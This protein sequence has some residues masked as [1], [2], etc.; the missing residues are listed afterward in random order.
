MTAQLLRPTRDAVAQACAAMFSI[1]ARRIARPRQ[2]ERLV[3]KKLTISHSRNSLEL[4]NSQ[5]GD[6]Y[7]HDPQNILKTPHETP[8]NI[9]VLGGGLTGLSTA[10]FLSEAL[11]KTR[12]TV[13]EGSGRTGGW[14]DGQTVDVKTPDGEKGTVLFERGARMVQVPSPGRPK[15]DDL[16]FWELVRTFSFGS[17]LSRSTRIFLL[18]RELCLRCRC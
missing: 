10:L 12:I 2:L 17:P 13:Y 9:A 1:S 8:R 3:A 15:L 16:P 11:P 7:R 5:T 6:R 18:T 4:I 14:I